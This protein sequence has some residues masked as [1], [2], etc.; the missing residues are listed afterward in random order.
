MLHIEW[1]PSI[2]TAQRFDWLPT[3][4]IRYVCSSAP[5]HICVCGLWG[6]TMYV[7][8]CMVS[9]ILQPMFICVRLCTLRTHS[10]FSSFKLQRHTAGS[11]KKSILWLQLLLLFAKIAFVG[12]LWHLF[13]TDSF[14]LHSIR[15]VQLHFV[16]FTINLQIRLNFP[17]QTRKKE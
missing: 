1:F 12:N 14:N 6:C 3:A 13:D 17:I 8:L 11:R 4:Y 10:Q 2:L 9:Y 15:F 5:K 16:R 7:M